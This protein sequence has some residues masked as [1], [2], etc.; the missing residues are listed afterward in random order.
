MKQDVKQAYQ[1]LLSDRDQIYMTTKLVDQEKE[2]YRITRE[3][4]QQGLATTID[5]SDAENSLTVA[6]LQL[7]QSY[8]NWLKDKANMRYLTGTI[9]QSD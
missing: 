1:S 2:R 9:Y 3:K 7:Q 5:L 8:I 6:E 4:Y